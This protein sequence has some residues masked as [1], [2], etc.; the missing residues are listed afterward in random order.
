MAKVVS[1]VFDPVIMIPL[2]LAGVVGFAFVNGHRWQV[3]L[4]VF[5]IDALL[6]G[7]F[8]MV[9]FWR[10]GWVDWDIHSRAERL[11][12]F[13]FTVVAH[14]A[15]VLAVYALGLVTLAQL[16]L[17]LWVVA[18]AYFLVTWFWKISVHVGVSATLAALVFWFWGSHYWWLFLV[19]V[20]VGWARI[21]DRD[22]SYSQVLLGGVLAPVI[23]AVGLRLFSLG[24]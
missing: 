19:P 8:F 15:G 23:V 5:I 24:M 21:V 14:G 17:V 1:K 4:A 18:L 3:Y 13:G 9:S 10:R 12:L 16:L 22:H 2:I 7:L 6:P 20:A 11:P